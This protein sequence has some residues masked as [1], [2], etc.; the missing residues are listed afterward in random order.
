M[1]QGIYN[2]KQTPQTVWI[3]KAGFEENIWNSVSEDF[4]IQLESPFLLFEKDPQSFL[5][6]HEDFMKQILD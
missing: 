2:C 4:L 3:N 1:L 5:F 6:Y